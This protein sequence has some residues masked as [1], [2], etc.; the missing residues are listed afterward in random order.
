[1]ANLNVDV[2]ET[3]PEL[4]AG[5]TYKIISAEEMQTERRGYEAVELNCEEIPTGNPAGSMLWISKRVMANT[6][7]GTFL[8]QF[9]ND[10]EKWKGKVFDVVIWE[11]GKRQVKRHR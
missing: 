10:L 7:L 8:V 11:E 4:E 5:K 1:M 9:G 6:K 3:P 2:V